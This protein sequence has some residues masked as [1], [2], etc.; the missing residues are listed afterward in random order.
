[1]Q[2]SSNGIQQPVT[3]K[4]DTT[5]G[6]QHIQ[7]H[8]IRVCSPVFYAVDSHPDLIGIPKVARVVRAGDEHALSPNNEN[9]P[10]PPCEP[11]IKRVRHA[12]PTDEDIEKNNPAEGSYYVHS[13]SNLSSPTSWSG[14]VVEQGS[15]F[16][17]V[18]LLCILI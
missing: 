5:N 4:T 18:L 9:P 14:D 7:Q 16:D 2:S 12:S 15:Y 1:M 8:V 13:P 17:S 10:S 11:L 3:I 6:Q